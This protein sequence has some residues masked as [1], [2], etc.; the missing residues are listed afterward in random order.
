MTRK[1][2]KSSRK[3]WFPTKI[4]SHHL[5]L[6]AFYATPKPYFGWP[7]K[8]LYLQDTIIYIEIRNPTKHI[9]TVTKGS[10]HFL[11]LCFKRDIYLSTFFWLIYLLFSGLH[12]GLRQCRDATILTIP[13][14]AIKPLHSHRWF[15]TKI[16]PNIASFPRWRRRRRWVQARWRWA[17]NLLLPKS[18]I[19]Y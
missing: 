3:R 17:H 1:N 12:W 10:C 16:R 5:Q 8:L 4:N 19:L 15:A 7:R 9:Y 18:S 13:L 6:V 11:L 2:K 14:E